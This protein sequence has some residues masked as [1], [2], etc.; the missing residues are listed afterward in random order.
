MRLE[1]FGEIVIRIPADAGIGIT[2][3]G[4]TG[5]DSVHVIRPRGIIKALAKGKARI[6]N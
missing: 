1:K 5:H 2:R 3:G 6:R 4:V